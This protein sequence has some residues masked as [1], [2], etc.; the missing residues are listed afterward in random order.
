MNYL[1]IYNKNKTLFIEAIK[2]PITHIFEMWSPETLNVHTPLADESNPSYESNPVSLA[3]CTASS[4]FLTP[5][6]S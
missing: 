4:R 1:K 6:L 5:N 3:F 2:S